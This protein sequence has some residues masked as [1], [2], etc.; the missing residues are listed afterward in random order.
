[1][2]EIYSNVFVGDDTDAEL[3][4]KGT[5]DGY[6][7]L[8]AAKEPFHRQMVGYIG[9]GA[10]KDSPEYL[11]A[12]RGNRMALNMVDANNPKFFSKEMIEAG[13]DFL[14]EGYKAGKKLFVHCNRGESRSPSVAMLFVFKRILNNGAT[15]EEA[16]AE[17]KKIYPDYAPNDGIRGHLQQ[18]WS[19]Y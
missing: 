1:M 7:I 5:I 15:F 6:F 18:Y 9:R 19:E 10:P 2:I 4:L 14:E 3:V 12:R 16:E 13:L 17:I 8:H 11:Y